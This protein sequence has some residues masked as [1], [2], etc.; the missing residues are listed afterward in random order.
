MQRQKQEPV[1]V[2][3]GH[4]GVA[5]IQQQ[6]DRFAFAV[7]GRPQKLLRLRPQDGFGLQPA[8]TEQVRDP[9][10]RLFPL[11]G[12]QP[13]ADGMGFPVGQQLVERG[14]PGDR[15]EH[16]AAGG[17]GKQQRIAA[18]PLCLIALR[19]FA[20]QGGRDPHRKKVGLLPPF[21]YRQAVESEGGA[22]IQQGAALLIQAVAK[23]DGSPPHFGRLQQPALRPDGAGRDL[24]P[25]NHRAGKPE[26]FPQRG[27][28][29]IG[30]PGGSLLLLRGEDRR[31]I[32]L[33]L[34]RAA[35]GQKNQHDRQQQRDKS[36]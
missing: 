3:V 14:I 17:V 32:I 9:Q 26:G 35:G 25:Q 21:F 10:Q 6:A 2:R 12:A 31:G 1:A 11:H 30:K 5:G 19:Q 20:A 22:Q 36:F 16:L 18:E 8:L 4:G 13:Q 7:A 28:I 34:C 15:R 33:G 29:G 27:V 23:G 24:F